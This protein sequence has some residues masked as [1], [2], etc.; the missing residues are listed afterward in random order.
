MAGKSWG[1]A[2]ALALCAALPLGAELRVAPADSIA[3]ARAP[4]QLTLT[5]AV[6]LVASRYPGR[7][8]SAQVDPVQGD[9]RHVHVDVLLPNE[10]TLMV[11]VS[12]A[13]GAIRNRIAPEPGPDSL[14]LVHALQYVQSRTP[15][16]VVAVEYDKEP[17]PHYHV[18]VLRPNGEIVRLDYD[19]AT[20]KLTRHVPRG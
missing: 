10:K 19:L 15:G 9:A 12:T 3:K 7:V 8:V 14:T 13:T 4:E 16:R 1:I 17:L 2:A 11:E 20:R 6:T 18:N 5:D